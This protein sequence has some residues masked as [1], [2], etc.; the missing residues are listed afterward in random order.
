[1][2]LSVLLLASLAFLI[3]FS[4]FAQK[5]EDKKKPAPSVPANTALVLEGTELKPGK[6]V[7]LSF[8]LPPEIQKTFSSYKGGYTK[9]K[10]AVALPPDYKPEVTY[11]ILVVCSTDS[12]N[13]TPL[14]SIDGFVSES[15]RSG[16]IV[17]AAEAEGPRPSENDSTSFY[18]MSFNAARNSLITKFPALSSSR[19]VPA[20]HSGGGKRAGLFASIMES[21]NLKVMGIYM[22][23]VN[24]NTMV[25]AKNPAKLRK[26]PI[27]ISNGAK[28]SYVPPAANKEVLESLKKGGF[29]NVKSPG[30]E[31]G[32]V[33][34]QTHLKEALEWFKVEGL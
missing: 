7:V 21:F 11:P 19:F 28:D 17:L 10:V 30:H 16:F 27:F 4:T 8:T 23:G 5:K 34:V 20:G 9:L 33:L 13:A 15:L 3:P 24:S 29:R 22:S 25:A 32:H 18:Y 14:S 1:M 2:R 6:K 26:V 31:G 12:G